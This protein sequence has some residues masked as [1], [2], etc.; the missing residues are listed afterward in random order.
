LIPVNSFDFKDRQG[1]VLKASDRKRAARQSARCR[2]AAAKLVSDR[3]FEIDAAWSYTSGMRLAL[4]SSLG[5][6]LLLG[7]CWALS[8]PAAIAQSPEVGKDLPGVDGDFR[9]VKPQ[10]E[11]LEPEP[12]NGVRDGTFKVGNWD[13]NVSGSLTV[14]IGTMKP[15]SNR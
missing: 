2:R 15:R 12:D 4:K 3:E 6:M 9:I 5:N 10:A 7:A 14:D 13:V 8:V 1:S 11:I